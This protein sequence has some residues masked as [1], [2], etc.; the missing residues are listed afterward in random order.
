MRFYVVPRYSEFQDRVCRPSPCSGPQWLWDTPVP[1]HSCVVH[2][3][4]KSG[5]PANAL[6]TVHFLVCL[7]FHQLS[8]HPCGEVCGR[9]LSCGQHNCEEPCHSG[10]C[11][12]CW[13]GVIYT[14]ITCRC[15]FSVLQPPQP[16]GCG[17]PGCPRPCD[18]PHACDHPVR[19][20]CHNEPTCPPCTVLLTKE[21]PGGNFVRSFMLFLV[22][23]WN[24]FRP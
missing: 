21:C 24:Y 15:G 9:R 22:Q 11:G 13:R 8:V 4:E 19:H 23:S 12:T 5:S 16:C 6:N 18:R 20:T 7:F 10:S 3:I 17:P 14:E 1:L 2:V